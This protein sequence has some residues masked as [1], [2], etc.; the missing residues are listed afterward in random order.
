MIENTKTKVSGLVNGSAEGSIFSANPK[1]WFKVTVE[2][3]L[4]SIENNT[5]SLEEL[6]LE[7]ARKKIT[8]MH[9]RHI[10]EVQ[11]EIVKTKSSE[12]ES[13]VIDDAF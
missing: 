13:F 3:D 7:Y 12:G 5:K 9:V 2:I 11:V 10:A 4:N 1:G 8:F 6:F